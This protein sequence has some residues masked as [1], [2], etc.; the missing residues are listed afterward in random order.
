M[1]RYAKNDVN[2]AEPHLEHFPKGQTEPPRY[3][4]NADDAPT[5]AQ[6]RFVIARHGIAQAAAVIRR[7]SAASKDAPIYRIDFIYILLEEL[8]DEKKE[9]GMALYKAYQDSD[10]SLSRRLTNW[11]IGHGERYFQGGEKDRALNA[12]RKALLI[13]PANAEAAAKIKALQ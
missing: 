4:L 7:F 9:D 6:L 1:N 2:S 10:P 5:P 13:D 3:D 12:Y 11:F 8:L